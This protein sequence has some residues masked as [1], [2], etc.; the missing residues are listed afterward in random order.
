MQIHREITNFNVKNAVLTIGTFDGVHLGHKEILRIINSKAK[1]IEGEGVVFTFN[2]HPRKVLFPNDKELTLLNTFEEKIE[3]LKS[4][5]INHLILY[6]FSAEFSKLSSDEF[7]EKL[8]FQQLNIKYLIV[9][10]DHK[11]GNDKLGDFD[12]LK[13]KLDKYNISSEKISQLQLNQTGISST[14]IRN[15]LLN[16]MIESANQ[17][18]GYSYSIS[19]NVVKGKQIGRTIDFPTANIEIKDTNKLIP[20]NGVYSVKVIIE[21]KKYTG[22]LN[23]GI[24]PT[25]NFNEK[26]IEVHILDFE[27]DIYGK[28]IKLEFEKYIRPE[29]KFSTLFELKNQI[30]LDKKTILLQ[31]K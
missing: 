12:I 28:E 27:K 17:S 9:G 20:K 5:G 16:G 30:N 11:F 2:P 6:P 14:N 7:I 4:S 13:S 31:Q 23:I 19:G 26:T 10:H 22:M 24:K 29:Q 18:L 8:L 3:I 25:L 21:N 15:F 1:E